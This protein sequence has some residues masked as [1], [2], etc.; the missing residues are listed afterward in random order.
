MTRIIY[1]SALPS[2][3]SEKRLE[4]ALRIIAK[5][6][7]K[8]RIRVGLSFVPPMRMKTLNK[9]YRGKDKETDVLSFAPDGAGIP[10][11]VK[12]ITKSYLGDIVICS[13]FA[14]KEARRRGIPAEEEI[15]RLFVHGLLHLRGYDH[16]TDEDELKMFK[17]QEEAVAAVFH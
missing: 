3:L 17:I 10:E 12:E 7:R 8:P 9:I 2:G 6:E 16:A 11:S 5:H 4:K 1:A 15:V 13:S 14:K